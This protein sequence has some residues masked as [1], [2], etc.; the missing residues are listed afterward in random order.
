MSDPV[1]S[2]RGL[3]V[4]F[5]RGPS[6][7]VA[8][9]DLSYDLAAGETLAIVGE[10]GSGKS[11]SSLAL[12][13]LLPP[14]A[15]RVESGTAFF[16]GRDLLAMTE[17]ER[18]RVR[19][20]RIAMIFQEPMT[21]LTPVLRIGLQ[22][23]EGLVAHAG[24]DRRATEMLDL[25]GLD[26]PEK[27]MRQF[28]HEL[29]GGMR[30]RVM[31][32]MAMA[33]DP[34]ILIAD[35]PTT[36]L[37]VTVQAQILDLMRR[38]KREFS[39]AIVLITHDMGVV[40]EMADR[41]VVMHEGEKVEEGRAAD[42]FARPEKP[43]TRRLLDAVPRL[44][45]RAAEPA[46]RA[47]VETPAPVGEALVRAEGLSKTFRESAWLFGSGKASAHAMRDVGFTLAEGETLALVGESGSGKST[48]GRAVLRLIEVDRGTI[49]I[50]GVDVRA[51]S[52][53][54]LRRARRRMQMV[55]QDPFA[56]LN[57]R[58]S[59]GALVA[60]PMTIHA[61]ATGS[62]LDDRVEA[63]FRRV[64]LG[65][66]HIARY[67]HE[68]SGG[69]RQRLC[70]ARA[71]GV[72]PRLIVADEPTSALDVSVQ[73]QVLE[74]ML[75]LQQSLGLAYLFISHDMAVVEEMAHRVA[76]MRQG[77]IVES[78][79]R[80]AVL[81]EARHPYTR[82]LLAAVPVPD[83]TRTRGVLPVLDPEAVPMGPLAAAAPGHLVAQAAA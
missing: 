62:E 3:S 25:V 49:E 41:V 40:A 18:R 78:G 56:A 73:A 1:L 10:S 42:L 75:E 48:T 23:T 52:G 65:P 57:P 43:Y 35:E 20:D 47:V 19:G 16:E 71:L 6:R 81:G 61:V 2:V 24:M 46:P 58:M 83:P 68:F 29:S 9:K 36:A 59:A 14:R 33:A 4:A 39:T 45:A 28:P 82:A 70:I 30:Q 26:R 53:A 13:G 32:A 5:G 17:A 44:G 21:S 74:L 77:R 69:Q 38:L 8:V 76:V 72:G 11:V 80:A 27:R 54:G 7:N 50:G 31:I 51:L 12:L 22:L 15:A 79:P 63:L 64:G 66:E 37:D 67:P 34:A 55:F 60:E